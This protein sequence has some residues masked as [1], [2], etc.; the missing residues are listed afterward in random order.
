[1]LPGRWSGVTGEVFFSNPYSYKNMKLSIIIPV[2]NE[3]GN[4]PELFR[5]FGDVLPQV[6][7]DYE[8]IAI[9]DGS[10]DGSEQV[11]RKY[12]AT[13]KRIKVINF[14]RNFGQTAALSAGIEYATGDI[15]IPMDSD[16]ENDPNDIPMLLSKMMEGYQV[17]S[18]WRVDR[19]EGSFLRRK[20]PSLLA[21]KLISFV[22]G[23]KLHDYG[24]IMKAYRSEVIKG[25]DLYGEMHRFVPALAAWQGAK[26][27]EVAVNY[28]PRKYG[29]SNYGLGRTF[30]VLLDLMLIRFLHRYLNRPMHFFGGLGFISFGLGAVAGILSVILKFFHARDFVETPLPVWSAMLII[31]GVQLIAFGILAEV[32]SRIYYS[33]GDRRQYLIREKIN[34]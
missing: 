29:K 3:E 16:L 20:L 5:R 32:M 14:R 15:I 34:L 22:T 2:Y 23:V 24:C 4:L 12:A 11:L 6:A 28:E 17:V 31:V 13:D 25:I 10:R 30:K 1:M 9:N 8:I 7:D 27:A 33:Q 21:N 26:V 19:W 18:G